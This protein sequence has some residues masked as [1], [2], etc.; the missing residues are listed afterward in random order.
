MLFKLLPITYGLYFMTHKIFVIK[1]KKSVD[2]VEE[3]IEKIAKSESIISNVRLKKSEN[4]VV[5]R[6]ILNKK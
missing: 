6:R 1:L 3:K 2:T 4:S 5:Q